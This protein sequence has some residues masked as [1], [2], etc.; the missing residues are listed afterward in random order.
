MAAISMALAA[1]IGFSGAS[2]SQK[3]PVLIAKS[4]DCGLGSA[5]PMLRDVIQRTYSAT[6]F[7][8]PSKD[9]CNSIDRFK[10]APP[11]KVYL[12]TVRDKGIYFICMT[13]SKTLPCNAP[14]A[15]IRP[16][17]S[18]ATALRFVYTNSFQ[19]QEG[20]QNQTVER[21]FIRPSKNIR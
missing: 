17:L 11:D 19:K 12:T 14:I 3:L 5:H 4:A 18:P 20:P 15:E 6:S 13:V 9:I 21:L 1:V 8:R 16:R 10:G 2:L 7:V